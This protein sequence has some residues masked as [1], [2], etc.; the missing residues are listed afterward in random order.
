MSD[1]APYLPFWIGVAVFA[2]FVI[3]HIRHEFKGGHHR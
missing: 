3:H 2:A 1:I